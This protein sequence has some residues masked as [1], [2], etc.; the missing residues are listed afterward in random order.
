MEYRS[1]SE[2]IPDSGTS[3]STQEVSQESAEQVDQPG[4]YFRGIISS[5]VVLVRVVLAPH[6]V[7]HSRV[8]VEQASLF[9]FSYSIRLTWAVVFV[10]LPVSNVFVFHSFCH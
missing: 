6:Q 2:N 5:S 4:Q 10:Y 9:C 1:D 3:R 7:M 8:C